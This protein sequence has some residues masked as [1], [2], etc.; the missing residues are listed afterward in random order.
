M[1]GVIAGCASSIRAL[2]WKLE[3]EQELCSQVCRYGHVDA[4]KGGV[5]SRVLTCVTAFCH[6]FLG[7]VFSFL[8]GLS[9]CLGHEGRKAR[10]GSRENTEVVKIS[11]WENVAFWAGLACSFCAVYFLFVRRAG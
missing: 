11:A 3:S 1:L 8:V 5:R 6:V 9:A 4:R 10:N 7:F 2:L